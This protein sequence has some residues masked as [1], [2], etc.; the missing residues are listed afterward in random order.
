MPGINNP[1]PR[2]VEHDTEEEAPSYTG[3]QSVKNRMN[4]LGSDHTSSPEAYV[5]SF[6][7]LPRT[8]S[9]SF[10]FKFDFDLCGA[11]CSDLEVALEQLLIEA[12]QECPRFHADYNVMCDRRAE[13]FEDELDDL[14]ERSNSSSGIFSDPHHN[15]ARI[16]AIV[17]HLAEVMV[18]ERRKFDKRWEQVEARTR[19]VWSEGRSTSCTSTSSRNTDE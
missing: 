2:D 17:V 18:Q 13:L 11:H 19:L 9:P 12:A 5:S 16:L 1:K 15:A 7:S 6:P 8:S 14:E 10:G 4:S 3:T